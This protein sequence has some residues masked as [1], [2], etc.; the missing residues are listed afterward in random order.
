MT[1]RKPRLT[2]AER[3]RIARIL[4]TL[5]RIHPTARTELDYHSPYELLCAVMLSAQTT[6]RRVNLVTPGLFARYPDVQALAG[7]DPE[8]VLTLV[9]SVNYA[10]TKAK[11]LVQMAQIVSERHGGE[12]PD[13]MEGLVSL[14]GVGRKTANVVLSIAFDVPAIAVD[15][16]VFRL[17]R[18]L[19]F[20]QGTTPEAVELDLMA[21]IPREDWSVAHHWL[22]LH[23]RYVCTA[24]KP[25]C[26]R[27]EL[28]PDCPA[29]EKR[30]F[31]VT[32]P[33]TKARTRRP[34]R[35]A[36]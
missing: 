20:S 22:I 6:D 16:H 12:V 11:H 28:A 4:S 36:T 30:R 25:D 13:T 14:P 10:P 8:A 27:C 9:G 17:S 32:P 2:T 23:G 35:T 31:D 3:E 19:G 24:Q 5:R 7:A 21:R 18:R 29:L 15:T 1:P 34:A 33:G 26:S